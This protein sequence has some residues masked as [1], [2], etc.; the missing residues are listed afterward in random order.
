MIE[1][2][3]RSRTI[4]GAWRSRVTR[5]RAH[6]ASRSDLPDG[7]IHCIG[8]IQVTRLIDDDTDWDVETCSAAG[9]IY[10][11]RITGEARQRRH[12]SAR[13]DFP[14][15]VIAGVG[16]EEIPLSVERE[17]P[18]IVETGVRTNAIR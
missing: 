12:Y 4:R 10:R 5:E 2:R 1:T 7:V 11:S 15:G 8:D 3:C 14:N 18:R 17:A 6:D 13:T 9:S 16:N